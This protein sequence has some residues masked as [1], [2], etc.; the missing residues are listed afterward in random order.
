MSKYKCTVSGCKGLHNS[1]LHDSAELCSAVKNHT[2]A[3]FT[4]TK[5]AGNM[6]ERIRFV[7]VYTATRQIA[8]SKCS[9]LY[10]LRLFMNS[11]ASR[12][13]CIIMP[14]KRREIGRSTPQA[15]MRRALRAS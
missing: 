12:R 5:I 2:V 11:K 3:P 8:G 4:W 15:R 14:P 7:P 9:I 10:H 6:P 1:L 13:S